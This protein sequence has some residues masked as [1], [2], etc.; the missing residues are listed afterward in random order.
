VKTEE[1][2]PNFPTEQVKEGKVT[3]VVPKLSAY[4]KDASDY[5]PS[6]A[7]V[8]YNPVMELNRDLSVLALQAYQQLINKEIRV[9]EPLAS[10]GVRGVRYATEISGISEVLINDISTKAVE[11]AKHNVKLNSLE[12]RVSVS[13]EDANC[14][15]SCHAA[16]TR[17]FNIID[18]DPFGSP[19]RYLDSAIRALRDNGLLA[20]TATDLA[21]LCGV[22]SK[23]CLRKYGGRPLR[24]EYCHELAVRLLSGCAAML[25]ARQDVGLQV[26]FSHS[27][28]HYI[29]VYAQI[30]FGAKRADESLQNMGHFLHCFSCLHRETANVPFNSQ[31]AHCPE[32]GVRM[33]YAGPLWLGKILDGKFCEAMHSE[34][35]R[36][37]F[38][39]STKIAQLLSLAIAEADAE[40]SYFVIDKLCAKLGL[41]VPPTKIVL[42]CLREKGFKAGPTHFSTRGIKTNVPALTLHDL[43][44]SITKN[45]E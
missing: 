17:R 3:V 35:T 25:A 45:K 4:M 20:L 11:I 1:F 34:N 41:R 5:A 10:S 19:V 24:T 23:A 26:V 15:L 39:N 31:I 28:D 22:H 7:P 21:P 12:N 30:K 37:A 33:D 9:C 38:R 18:L 29:R 42:N 27:T 32:C 2:G 6:K 13:H 44:K 16:P 40:P 14:L 43:V 8:F 36:H